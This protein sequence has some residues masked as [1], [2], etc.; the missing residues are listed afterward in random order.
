[1]MTFDSDL[2]VRFKTLV[3]KD[4]EVGEGLNKKGPKKNTKPTKRR[5]KHVFLKKVFRREDA[6]LVFFLCVL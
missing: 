4:G 5:T 1:M 3:Q 6:S 2:G